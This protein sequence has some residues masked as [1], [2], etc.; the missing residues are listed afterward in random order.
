MT[1]LYK[2]LRYIV[3]VIGRLA[4]NFKGIDFDK[5]PKDGRVVVCCN[6]TSAW[7]AVM[8][9]VCCKER[10]IHFMA[11]KELFKNKV[12]GYIFKMAGSFPVDRHGNDFGA[13]KKA[14]KVLKNEGLLCIFPE[15]TRSKTGEMQQG[16]AG[17][18]LIAVGTKSP[19]VPVSIY[20]EGKARLFSK[21]TLR[22]GNLIPYETLK[23]IKKSEQGLQ[24][25][26][27]YVMNDIKTLW[28]M[29]H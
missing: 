17:A 5:I 29:K 21:T 20:R 7:D 26:I 12:L 2:I 10:Q 14:Q 3:L 13:I 8:L 4:F 23:E 19:V 16:K 27:N 18:A 11:K 22:C 6:H 15:G 24:G 25:A 28:E 9:A 1:T